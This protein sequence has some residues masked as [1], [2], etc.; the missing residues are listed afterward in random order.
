V[1]FAFAVNNLHFLRSHRH[2]LVR[3]ACAQGWDVHVV[4]AP[5]ENERD[6]AA[7]AE[8][9]ALGV[10]RHRVPLSRAGTSPA[11]LTRT[12]R[13]LTA[14]YRAIRPA[15]VHQVTPKLV[16]LGS[17]AARR[18]GVPALVN[19]ISGL[20]TVF[21]DDGQQGR[22]R[23]RAARLLYAAALRH[24]RQA[25]IVQNER[26]E[27]TLRTLGLPPATRFL[28]LPGSGVD[29][30]RFRPMPEPAGVPVVLLPARMLAD[31]GVLVFADAAAL[32]RARGVDV[33]MALSGPL[34]PGNPRGLTADDLAALQQRTGV[35]WWGHRDDMPA[36]FAGASIVCLPSHY[37]EG[38][39]LALAEAAAAGRPIITT[40]L[41]GC[42]DTVVDGVSGLLV[43]PR[44]PAA[45]A[46]AIAALA[47][48]P[49]RR[50][51]M[52]VAARRHAEA[53]FA[54]RA[55]VEAH[56]AVYDALAVPPLVA[57]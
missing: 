40:D 43:P 50:A 9:D 45:L 54:I 35:E 17:L 24:P 29:L 22:L 30:A 52:G 49:T 4:S 39:P 11:D 23:S 26:D 34:D 20:G 51:R 14:T 12:V 47:A 57:A 36:V 15:I 13:A 19:A 8:Y 33:R 31:K 32:L 21:S 16:T 55:I 2:A 25:I 44:S 7:A 6:A 5:H 41:P 27:G 3:A 37:G 53:H 46:E 56:L 48:D 28:R 18:A 10:T 38:L 1:R 42:R